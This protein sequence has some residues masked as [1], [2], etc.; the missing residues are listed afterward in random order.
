MEKTPLLASVFLV[1]MLAACAS[2]DVC[3]QQNCS[4]DLR[5]SSLVR[6]QLYS[7]PALEVDLLWV[8]TADRVVYLN[9]AADSWL[10]YYDAEEIARAVPGVLRVVNKIE[11][12]SPYG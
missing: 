9:G 11:V 8:Q 4:E 12:K 1:T 2:P 7:H 3:G 6:Q 10:E 5:L